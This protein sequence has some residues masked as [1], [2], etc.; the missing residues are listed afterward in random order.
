MLEH[1]TNHNLNKKP[2]T[3][4]F[5]L[6]THQCMWTPRQLRHELDKTIHTFKTRKTK[7]QT[8][9]T[10]DHKICIVSKLISACG[11]QSNWDMRPTKQFTHSKLANISGNWN[12]NLTPPELSQL[13]Q[14]ACAPTNCPSCFMPTKRKLPPSE[15]APCT[16]NMHTQRRSLC[17]SC[18][19][20]RSCLV[21]LLGAQA[22]Q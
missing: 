13:F 9:E 2:T 10:H 7:N 22:P 19:P 21:S 16:R 6:K 5:T 8:L 17:Q 11:Q 14:R 15:T 20:G 18:E 3:K 4:Q 12:M 1:R